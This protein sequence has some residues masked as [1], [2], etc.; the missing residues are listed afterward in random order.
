MFSVECSSLLSSLILKR[1]FKK[2]AANFQ[3]EK[4]R[5]IRISTLEPIKKFTRPVPVYFHPGVPAVIKIKNFSMKPKISFTDLTQRPPRSFRVRLGNHVIL[6]RMLDKGR[7]TLAKKNGE[8]NYNS[9]TDQRLVQF[10]G[11]DADAMLQE[12][13]AGKGDG[14]MLEWVQSHSKTPRSPWEIEAWSA[15][16]EKRGPD[17][18]A[19][20]LTL[21][22]GYLAQHSKTREDVKTWFEAIELDDYASFGGKA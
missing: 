5:R 18:D 17:S 19:E 4:K 8:Y 16:M 12:L 22:A 1:I 15:F 7:A 9:A 14:E 6:A 10:L 21:F 20:T 13:S 3:V 11:F 2:H